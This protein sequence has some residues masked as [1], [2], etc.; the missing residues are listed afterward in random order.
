[1]NPYGKNELISFYD[2][3][4]RDFGDHP[5]AVRWTP[6]GQMSRFEALLTMAGD[7]SGKKV[8]DF[9]CGKGDLYGFLAG[10]GII[11]RYTGIDINSNMIELASKKYPE[12][13]FSV[14]DIEEENISEKFDIIF[15][16][17][18]FNL[19]IAGIEESMHRVLKKLYSLCRG[20]MHINLLS[21]DIPARDPQL[22]YV[23]PL[24][25][26]GFTTKELSTDYM[27]RDDLVKG[28]LFLTIHR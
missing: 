16:C 25:I 14:V 17:G 5:Q 12:A 20:A 8:L 24:D 6:S 11:T 22:F 1:M 13:S 15:A 19:L 2:R 26:T 10:R 4:L 18:V 3:H 27:L 21:Y 7:I 23:R 28:D 9:G